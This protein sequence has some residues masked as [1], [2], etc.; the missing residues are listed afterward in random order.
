MNSRHGVNEAGIFRNWLKYCQHSLWMGLVV[1]AGCASNPPPPAPKPTFE[2]WLMELRAEALAAGIRDVTLDAALVDVKPIERVI[3]LDRQ[4]PESVLTFEQYLDRVVPPR[5]IQA[6]REKFAQHRDALRAVEQ[7]YGVPAQVITALWGIETD[8]GRLPGNFSVVAAL[9]TLAYE[10]RRAAFFRGEL[11][12]ALHILDAGDITPEA[13]RGSWAGAMGQTQFMPS[14]FRKYA[15]DA[16]GDGHRDIWQSTDDAFASAANYLSSIG[17]AR[18]QPWGYEVKLPVEFDRNLV[19]LPIL[20]PVSEWARVGVRLIGGDE[21]PASELNASV[22]QPSGP[23][24][25]AFLVFDNF[26]IVMQ[27]NRS[28]YF[29]AAVGTLSDAIAKTG[30]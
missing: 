21:L 18:D 16:D 4:Q 3:E 15:V 10:G 9:A 20:K 25:R 11:L 2:Q 1:L 12:D 22:V 6:G 14:T 13:M 19:G 28:T 30:Q 17:W 27:W 26:R 24:G 29:G 23:D 8:Y 5:R 7:K